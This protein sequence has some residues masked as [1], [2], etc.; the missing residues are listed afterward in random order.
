VILK[1]RSLEGSIEERTRFKGLSF[2]ALFA[3]ERF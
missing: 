1:V 2:G 3:Q